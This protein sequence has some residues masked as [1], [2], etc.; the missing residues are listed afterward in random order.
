MNPE[1]VAAISV[2]G[3]AGV[4][5]LVH[6]T[7]AL[8]GVSPFGMRVTPELVGRGRPDHVALTFDDGP[9]TE[10]TPAFLT[11][12]DRLGWRATFFMLGTR[13]REAPS[14]VAE[15]A[16]AGHEVAVHGDEHR[17]MLRRLPGSAADDIRRCRDTLAEATGAMPQW[18]R[19]PFGILSFGALRGARRANLRTVLWTTWGRDW[20]K[21]ATP[22]TVTADVLRR[23]V[24]GGTVLLH[25]CDRES[26]PGS[27]RSALGALPRIADELAARGLSVGP[28]REH[29]IGEVPVPATV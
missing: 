3:V 11:E 22:E 24:G 1:L 21:E 10:S 4:A 2:A 28:V 15:V 26:Y 13:A 27:W 17:N 7:P 8:A 14:L 29:G 5:G 9:D 16:A 6:A 18:F 25:D 20:R 23:Y 19:P 12:L